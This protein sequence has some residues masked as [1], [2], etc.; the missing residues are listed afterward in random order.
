[1]ATTIQDRLIDLVGNVAIK[2]PCRAATT[3]NITLFGEQTVGGVAVE[4]GDRVLVKNQ[5]D[6]E[7]NGIWNVKQYNWTRAVDLAEEIDVVNGTIVLVVEG[8]YANTFF[9]LAPLDD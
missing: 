6:Q 1:M 9:K 2:A 3:A 8:Q 7:E 5:T 4:I